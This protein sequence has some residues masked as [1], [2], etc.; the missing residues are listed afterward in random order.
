MHESRCEEEG[1]KDCGGRWKDHFE[2]DEREEETPGIEESVEGKS[3]ATGNQRV[4][5]F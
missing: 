2:Y 1:R 5:A 3:A 4:L